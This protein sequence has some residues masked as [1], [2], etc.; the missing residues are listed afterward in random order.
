[1]C[2]IS[3][4]KFN[5]DNANQTIKKIYFKQ[6]GRGQEGYGFVTLDTMEYHK[7][8]HEQEIF[9]LLKEHGG[10][11]IL[12]HHRRPTST[13]NTVL[14]AQPI[15]TSD[16][17]YDCVYYLAHNGS[18]QNHKEL[19]TKHKELG[20][21]YSSLG[22][23]NG[24]IGYNDSEALLHELAMCIEGK[25]KMDEFDARGSMAFVLIQADRD[26]NKLEVFFGRNNNSPLN[27]W[28]SDN[29]EMI[30]SSEGP[31]T[32]V[33][34]DKLYSMGQDGIVYVRDLKMY[35]WV[36]SITKPGEFKTR[37]E[38]E[39]QLKEL[40]V[41][42]DIGENLLKQEN[43]PEEIYRMQQ[44]MVAITNDIRRVLKELGERAK[45]IMPTTYN[46]P[47]KTKIDDV[48]DEDVRH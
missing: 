19:F 37:Y 17:Y 26:G 30:V 41:Q 25:Q 22:D 16:A 3:F 48:D 11:E 35:T 36:I 46:G 9:K 18:I 20:I 5:E 47:H 4:I 44:E 38:L 10:K 6:K 12:F 32:E 31:G 39:E 14:G 42:K 28:H 13:D 23:H 45:Y 7:S 1:M 15:F 29:G 8:K 40:K 43:D 21:K 34:T 24:I 27:L 2:G 33:K